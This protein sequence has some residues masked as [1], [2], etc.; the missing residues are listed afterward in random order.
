MSPHPSRPPRRRQ[1][2]LD[3]DRTRLHGHR[4]DPSPVFQVQLEVQCQCLAVRVAD[5]A[6]DRPGHSGRRPDSSLMGSR[7]ELERR[8]GAA[9]AAAAACATA[10]GSGKQPR[11]ARRRAAGPGQSAWTRTPRRDSWPWAVM[12][13]TRAGPPRENFHDG[14][15]ARDSCAK[16]EERSLSVR[17]GSESGPCPSPVAR[18]EGPL[19]AA[20]GHRD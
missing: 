18:P 20:C 15:D 3:G 6:S 1:C 11:R 9:S 2:Q 13:R 12:R 17:V 8:Q 19:T 5:R 14:A 16:L 4:A 10:C 7:V